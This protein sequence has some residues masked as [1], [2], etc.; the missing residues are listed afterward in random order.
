MTTAFVLSGGASLGSV[1]VGMLAALTEHGIN[2]DFVIGSSVGALNAAW[3][4]TY[5]GRQ[6]I[7]SL[8]ELWCSLG[9]NDVFP[10]RPLAGLTGFLGRRNSLVPSDGLRSILTKRLR[11]DRIEN[12]RIPLHIV[13]TEVTHGDE[14]VLSRGSAIDALLASTAIPGVFPPVTIDGRALMDGGVADNTPVSSAVALGATRIFVLPTGYACGLAIPPKGAL[15]MVLQALSLLIAQRLSFDIERFE[16]RAEL[17]VI[18]PLC[19]LDVSPV[20]FSKSA[21]LIERSHRE[22][23][24]WLHKRHQV[25]G[26]ACLVAPHHHTGPMT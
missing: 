13:A 2:P 14:V 9:R 22:T 12:A 20:D 23:T 7:L 5:P 15:G 3:V 18:P 11:L 19:P 16:D 8:S 10:L 6:G 21:Q 24:T 17:H 26:Q 25:H 4:A 1:Q